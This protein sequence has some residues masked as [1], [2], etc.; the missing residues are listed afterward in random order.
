MLRV[1]A[2]HF[3]AGATWELGPCGWLCIAE[4]TAPILRWMSGKTAEEVFDWLK[5]KRYQYS[6]SKQFDA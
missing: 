2:P 1:E 5:K 6:W 4:D 3:V